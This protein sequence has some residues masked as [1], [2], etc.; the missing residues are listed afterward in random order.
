[1]LD[2][3]TIKSKS[4]KNE[5]L[6]REE[7]KEVLNCPDSKINELIDTVYEIRKKYK[8]N[9]VEIQILT[10]AKS[11]NC[12]QDCKYCAQSCVSKANIE[13]YPL[14]EYDKLLQHG[15]IGLDKKVARHCIGLS[16]IKFTDKQIDDFCDYV[17]NLKKEVNTDICCSIGFLTREQAKKLKEAGVNRINHNLNTGRNNYSNICS[18]HTYDERIK[19][20]E[21][22]QDVG[23]EMCCGGI[24]GLGE[25]DDDII[26]MLMDVKN[27]NPKSVPINFLIPIKGTPF[28]KQNLE[29]L[30]PEYCLKVLCLA[31]LLNPQA[32]VRCAAGRE[33]YIKEKQNLMLKIV[34]SIFASGYLTADGQGIDDTIKLVKSA[35]FEYVV[36]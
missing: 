7:C 10:N 29:K 36:E 28:E 33:L 26:D 11:G 13:K 4:L 21:M 31:R 8:G 24:I 12:S 22:F 18:T 14:I 34:N 5:F 25:N 27:I 3:K 20:I 32:D 1:M 23:F 35:G 16:G 17:K 19:N 15:K 9:L 30:T 6:T 2:L